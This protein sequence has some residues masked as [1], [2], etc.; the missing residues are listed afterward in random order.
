MGQSQSDEETQV[1]LW[2][3]QKLYKK[4]AS[5]CPSGNLHLH[6]FKKIFGLGTS[7]L[8]EEESEYMDSIFRSFDTNQDDA[9]DF[10][11]Y[12]AAVHLV[13]RGK[14]ED[15]LRWSFKVY[16]SDGNG[17]LEKH[18]VKHIIKIIYAIK[19]HSGELQGDHLTPEQICNQIFQIVDINQDGQIS[20]EEF[21]EG[22]KKDEW[23]LDH[24][25]LDVKPCVWFNENQSNIIE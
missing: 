24:L 20:L 2:Q 3:I 12:V 9:I 17:L 5:E 1:E 23:V 10:L 18:E 14:L 15:R 19:K 16:D 6:E 13:L 22:A 8:S 25:K 11:E 21:I 4:F 7:Q